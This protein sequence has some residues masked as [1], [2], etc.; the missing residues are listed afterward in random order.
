LSDQV[1]PEG[2]LCQEVAFLFSGVWFAV[3]QLSFGLSIL[4]RCRLRRTQGVDFRG[5]TYD[6]V[7]QAQ[8]DCDLVAL[9]T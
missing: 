4:P 2:H 1:T 3:G 5:A 7:L 9:A 8:P 6:P